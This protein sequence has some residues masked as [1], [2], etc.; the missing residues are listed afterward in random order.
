M[1]ARRPV[2]TGIVFR[3]VNK[4][5]TKHGNVYVQHTERKKMCVL[6]VAPLFAGLQVSGHF[7]RVRLLRTEIR[8]QQGRGALVEPQKSDR[9]T[10]ELSRAHLDAQIGPQGQVL[11]TAAS[12]A[13]RK[14]QVRLPRCGFG[15]TA[16]FVGP[17]S[18]CAFG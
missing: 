1:R 18:L 3:M 4:S 6:I 8:E 16:L 12:F 2:P 13:A 5:D 14:H 7:E 15:W 11:G 9:Q 17:I 10:S